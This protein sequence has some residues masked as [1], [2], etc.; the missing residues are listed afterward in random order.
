M[1]ANGHAEAGI[2]SSLGNDEVVE[3]GGASRNVCRACYAE[4]SGSDIV[5]CMV[6]QLPEVGD[7][8]Y[9]WCEPRQG[10]VARIT[11]SDVFI[12]WPWG[13]RDVSS[14][15]RW[16]GTMA[17]LRR[18]SDPEWANTP[19]RLSPK[20]PGLHVGDSCVVFIPRTLVHVDRVERYDPSFD[21]GWL[22]A[23]TAGL[24][25]VEAHLK[26]V[27]NAGY[28]LYLGGAEPVNVEPGGSPRA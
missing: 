26:D 7:L 3:F 25:V 13:E 15:Y 23:P 12:E 20:A 4:L 27:P 16:D 11:A 8:I 28:T 22:P 2:L 10:R 17:L 24:E 1:Q 19:W 21:I 5:N 18:D 6:D 9:V 14:R